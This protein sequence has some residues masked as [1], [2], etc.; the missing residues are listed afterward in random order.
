[1]QALFNAELL[2]AGRIKFTA[3][4]YKHQ[5]MQGFCLPA[6]FNEASSPTNIIQCKKGYDSPAP[7]SVCYTIQEQLNM[8][9][10]LPV[11]FNVRSP[12]TGVKRSGNFR[13]YKRHEM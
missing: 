13:F 7:F 5:P 11:S 2:L 3:F 8:G 10:F 12:F 4:S 9:S 1:M 6:Q